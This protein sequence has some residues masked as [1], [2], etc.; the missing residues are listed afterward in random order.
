[1]WTE[2]REEDFTKLKEYLAKPPILSKHTPN[3]SFTI[4]LFRLLTEL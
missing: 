3:A 4:V 2:E 1:M